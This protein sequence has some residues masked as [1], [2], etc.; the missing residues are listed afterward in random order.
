MPYFSDSSQQTVRSISLPPPPSL[1][2]QVKKW[3]LRSHKWLSV[4][5]ES[6]LVLLYRGLGNSQMTGALTLGTQGSSR[7]WRSA[8]VPEWRNPSEQ[9]DHGTAPA[10]TVQHSEK[11]DSGRRQCGCQDGKQ[12]EGTNGEVQCSFVAVKTHWTLSKP[13]GRPTLV[14]NVSA[15]GKRWWCWSL[16]VLGRDYV[17]ALCLHLPL[18]CAITLKLLLKMKSTCKGIDIYQ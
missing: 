14:T 2:L 4:T 7:L 3:G 6:M 15:C 16:C 17:G 11:G 10:R 5:P 1:F 12:E 13:I 8:Y 18:S 9:D